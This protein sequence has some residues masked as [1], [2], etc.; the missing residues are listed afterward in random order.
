[1]DD[2]AV[3]KETG[4]FESKTALTKRLIR[5]FGNELIFEKKVSHFLEWISESYMSQIM[6]F[7]PHVA[8]NIKPQFLAQQC[9]Y[10]VEP[11]FITMADE[12]LVALSLVVNAKQVELQGLVSNLESTNTQR[13]LIE[14]D[15]TSYFII[16]L[17]V[18]DKSL[19]FLFLLETE[20]KRL[21]TEAEQSD[22]ESIVSLFSHFFYTET[23]EAELFSKE[24]VLQKAI[25]SSNDGYWHIDLVQNQMHFSRQWKR[26]LGFDENE[27]EDS[28]ATFE[29]MLH[30]EDRDLVLQVLDPYMKIGVGTYECE[31]RIKNKS[32]KYLWVLT[33]A[34]V[35]FSENGIPLQF[36]ATNTD[37]TSRID[38]KQKLANSEAKFKRLIGSIHEIIFEIDG[39]GVITF[40]N[41][42]WERHLLLKVDKTIG[43]EASKYIHPQDRAIAIRL[44]NTKYSGTV[45]D[46]KSEELRL[47]AANGKSVWMEIHLTLKYNERKVLSEIKGTLINIDE[48]KRVEID[49]K[50]GENRLARISENIT[51]LITE[52]NEDGD[53]LFISSAVRNMLGRN[54]ESFLGKNALEDVHPEDKKI[55]FR[56][57][58]KQLLN[59]AK[60]VVEKYRVR[61]AEGDYIWVET[62]MQPL[63]SGSGKRTFIAATRD[64]SVRMKVEEGMKNALKK[65]KD[66]NEL[67]SRF[68]TMTSHEFRT[69]LSNIQSSV[70]LLEMYAE[71]LGDRFMKPFEKHFSKIT[72]QVS[73]IN[74]LLTNIDTLGKIESSEMPFS[75][76]KQ[77]LIEFVKNV[78]NEQIKEEFNDRKV[79]LKVTGEPEIQ[80]F[81]PGLFDNLICNIFKNSLLY[82]TN[83]EIECEILFTEQGFEVVVEDKGLGI[84]QDDIKHLFT[85]F[86]R[87]KNI[88]NLN[89]PGNGLGLVISK[90]IVD[91]HHGEIS[92][93]SE[94]NLGTTVKIKF[95]KPTL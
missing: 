89:I 46:Y 67:K 31:Y 57:I 70:G 71:D 29:D 77:D 51:D 63:I 75:P 65:E 4:I 25:E 56:N 30:P 37:I 15:I 48:R 81:D 17:S 23:L 54:P 28:F 33:R 13:V 35:N 80:I 40:L 64:I 5:L 72:S 6:V 27:V 18:K 61:N 87:A 10:G 3:N 24:D 94:E 39:S 22:L 90:R 59:G 42:A 69:P 45:Y 36:V 21:W 60:R 79:N 58:F 55:A 20:V 41:E 62:I 11:A 66:L 95:P 74:N 9:V 84:P 88:V 16:P 78:I 93:E 2:F 14:Q 92:L 91:L 49:K 85:S 76:V 34:N 43:T 82:S 38:Y 52:V 1:M 50:F 83:E 44:L 8:P 32:G 26:M 73:R 86:F 47:I 68:I 19:G 7:M 12:L 53:Y